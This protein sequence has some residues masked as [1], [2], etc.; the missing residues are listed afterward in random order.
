MRWR[1]ALRFAT[2]SFGSSKLRSALTVLGFAVG[3]G[4]VL[5]V[6]TLGNAGEGRVEEEIAKLGVSKVW[7]RQKTA[8]TYFTRDDSVIL[9]EETGEPACA[10]AYAVA[11]VTLNGRSDAAYV[12]G[13][14]ESMDE[15]HGL[16]L[17]LGRRLI[18]RDFRDETT[19]CLID[20]T[21]AH[22]FGNVL[23][24]EF[25][26][27]GHRRFTIVG[28]VETMHG[29]Y[30]GGASGMVILP[31]P[32]YLDTFPDGITEIILNVRTG[33]DVPK[34]AE[35][36][37]NILVPSDE[38]RVETLEK[39]IGASLEVIRIFV[40]VLMA[41]AG[42]C[43]LSGGI[44]VMNVMLLS[45][46]ERR[47]E[48]GMLKAIGATA[49]QVCELFLLEAGVFAMFGGILGYLLGMVMTHGCA[50]WI[51]IEGKISLVHVAVLLWSA[52]VIGLGFGILPAM[53]ASKLQPVDALR[54]E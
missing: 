45:V 21:L 49:A 3:I 6:L 30:G 53:Q 48:I 13:F 7:I 16:K 10:G 11:A 44:G 42:V 14:D 27:V 34:I 39:E 52:I 35:Q 31:L 41:V 46:R 15:V 23:P 28:I 1:D 20:D 38:F 32:A 36:V 26:Y 12:T 24:G 18:R 25:L 9:A 50:L 22:A 5:T 19:V 8:A 37:K 29:Q 43:M 33:H 2:I 40:M 51:G 4:A 47:Q 54:D 17:L